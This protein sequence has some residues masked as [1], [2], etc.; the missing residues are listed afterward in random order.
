MKVFMTGGTGFVGTYLSRELASQGH[1]VTILTRREKPPAPGAP[2]LS[3]VTGDPTQEGPWMGAVPEH[4]W[5]ITLA[6]ATI[7]SRWSSAYKQEIYDSR[8]RTTRNLVIALA[9]GDRRQ[10]LCSTSAVG[11]YG[12]RGDEILTEESPQDSYFLSRLSEDWEAEALKA[13]ELGIRVVIT[14]F[15]IVLGRGGGALGQMTPMFKRFLGGILGSGQQWFSWI[16]QADH[17]RAFSF[18]QEH[19]E[20][21]GPVNFTAPQPVRNW[22]LTKALARVLHRPAVLPA[23]E[24]MMRLV[25]GEFADALLTGQRVIPKKLLEA[26]FKFNFSTIEAALKDLLG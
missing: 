2:G 18:I 16:H 20:I 1:E 12:P 4:D 8:I 7:F 19:A 26:G 24:F 11:Y 25:L 3:F 9:E 23:P 6:G 5:I 10:L 17:A 14:R 21:H 15:G 13:Q 22:E